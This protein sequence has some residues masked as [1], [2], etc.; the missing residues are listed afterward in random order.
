[1][2][3]RNSRALAHPSPLPL[4]GGFPKSEQPKPRNFGALREKKPSTA[5]SRAAAHL[6]LH[7]SL[8]FSLFDA[9]PQPSIFPFNSAAL[10]LRATRLVLRCISTLP[11]TYP[12]LIRTLL[13]FFALFAPL[14]PPPPTS[15]S[16][17]FWPHLGTVAILTRSGFYRAVLVGLPC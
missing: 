2:N 5:S 15:L 7:I 11:R 8:H 12:T 6:S 3:R 1:M 14:Y 4:N 13:H 9:L 17:F 16:P 10:C